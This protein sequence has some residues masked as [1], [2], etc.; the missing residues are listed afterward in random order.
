MPMNAKH[1]F[2]AL[3]GLCASVLVG[4]GEYLLHFDALGRFSATGYEFMLDIPES[5][6]TAGHF[7]GV[8]GA[9]LYP[10]GC[11]HIYLMLRP[12]NERWA[13]AAFLIGTFGF[14][15]GVVWI[16]SRASIAALVQIP[17]TPEV[18][19]MISLYDLRYETL[20]QVIRLTTFILSGIIVWLALSGRSHYP[21]W[22]ALFNPI[23][24]IIANFILFAVVPAVGKHTM[25]IAL[26][27]AFFIFFLLSFVFSI[28]AQRLVRAQTSD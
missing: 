18:L 5:R 3:L 10:I 21:K 23:I 16:G 26:N 6:A 27:V 8:I 13:F 9:T 17:E 28:K 1:V 24:L 14:I 20:L 7:L 2:T 25:P 22:M 15:V 19:H 12:A 4:A 11:Y